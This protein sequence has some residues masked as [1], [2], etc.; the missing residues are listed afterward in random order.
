M[1]NFSSNLIGLARDFVIGLLLVIAIGRIAGG[2]AGGNY[3]LKAILWIGG[4]LTAAVIYNV[5][6]HKRESRQ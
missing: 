3:G 2:I 6:A 4:V 5:V 1:P